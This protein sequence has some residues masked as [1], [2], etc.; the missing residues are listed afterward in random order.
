M[1]SK[2]PTFH[3]STIIAKPL[4]DLSQIKGNRFYAKKWSK[5]FAKAPQNFKDSY[6]KKFNEKMDELQT[7]ATQQEELVTRSGEAVNVFECSDQIFDHYLPAPLGSPLSS[8]Y[9]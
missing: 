6:E 5:S 8:Q 4:I 7:K 3:P 2:S 9:V 1:K